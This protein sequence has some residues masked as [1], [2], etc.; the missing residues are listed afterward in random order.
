MPGRVP[1]G[2]QIFRTHCCFITSRARPDLGTFA[3]SGRCSRRTQQSGVAA[4]NR[5]RTSDEFTP[6]NIQQHRRRI[7]W[8]Q[9]EDLGQNLGAGDL[10]LPM[11]LGLVC[12]L[13]H[14]LCRR[15]HA[16][17]VFVATSLI[18][19]FFGTAGIGS[20]QERRRRPPGPR[21]PGLRDRATQGPRGAC[22]RLTPNAASIE[23]SSNKASK[24]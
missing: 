8:L 11:T 1:P 20:G 10:Q 14:F 5:R 2:R 17:T 24:R 6:K 4:S 3:R 13:E 16:E 7:W 9:S 18:L 21:R 23:G 19:G 12:L 15:R 22:C